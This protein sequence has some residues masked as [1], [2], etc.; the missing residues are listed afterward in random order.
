MYNLEFNFVDSISSKAIIKNKQGNKVGTIIFNQVTTL[1]NN[2]LK[3]IYES[4]NVNEVL[5]KI[6]DMV[7]NYQEEKINE[8]LTLYKKMSQ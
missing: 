6:I 1:F 7:N 2:E 3:M 5:N 8:S 4:T